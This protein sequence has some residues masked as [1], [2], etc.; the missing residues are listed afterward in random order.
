MIKKNFFSILTAA[1]IMYLSMASSHTFD[2]VPLIKIP[3]FD[4]VVHF[5]MYFSLMSV[6]ILENRKNISSTQGL[7]IIG[8]I[9]FF[10]G[11]VI[12]IMQATLTVTRSGSVYDALADTLGILVSML[13]WIAIRKRMGKNSDAY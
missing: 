12:E 1:V 8:L 3:N 13:L 10:Y 5:T 6:M 2:K 7:F 11:I 4:K 9:P